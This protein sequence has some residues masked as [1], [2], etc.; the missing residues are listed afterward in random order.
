MAAHTLYEWFADSATAHPDHVALEARDTELTYRE[1]RGAADALA[2]TLRRHGIRPGDRVGLVAMRSPW[3]YAGYLAVLRAG[4]TVVPLNPAFPAERNRSIAAR[5]GLRGVVHEGRLSPVEA[6]LPT[7]A[8]ANW[9]PPNEDDPSLEPYSGRAEDTAYILFT[10]GSTGAPKGVPIGH[11]NVS[12]YL[13]HNIT[14]YEVEPNH[15]LTQTFDL[16]FDPSVFDMFVA[17]GAGATVVVPS[18][19]DVRDPVD[20][21]NRRQITHW[22]SVPS[23]VSL[24]H[25]MRRLPPGRMTGLRWSLFAGEQLTIEQAAA[26]GR[27]APASRIENIYGPTELT[28]TCTGYQ[29]P[30]DPA[31]WPQTDNR[32]VPIG[33]CY[34]H[35]EHVVLSSNGL[36]GAEGELCVRGSQ[37]FGGYL[38]PSDD[39]GRF[40]RF[41]LSGDRP[42]RPVEDAVRL[43]EDHWYRTGDRVRITSDGTM[44]HLGRL[45][46]QVQVHGYRVEL[47]EV[48]A[49]L[50]CHPKVS[51]AVVLADETELRAVYTGAPSSTGELSEWLNRSLPT[52]MIPRRYRH[53]D[54]LPLNPHGKVDRR[55]LEALSEVPA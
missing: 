15:R 6:M 27:A 43:T 9:P 45:D 54:V 24:A 55:R 20:F 5:S 42:A 47:G 53:V 10:S 28:I 29:L 33:F 22:F 31:R 34:P 21:V 48:E 30:R 7:G 18:P 11:A 35:L 46:S 32:T 12:P 41:D 26:W 25:R 13:E 23:V 8:P 52:Y 4:A 38:D 1:L 16:T 44:T 40:M 14:R 3:T 51:E 2:S 19:E 37:R 17:W 50:R 36:P 39:G 49:A